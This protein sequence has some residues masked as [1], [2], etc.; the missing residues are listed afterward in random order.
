MFKYITL[1]QICVACLVG[2]SLAITVM[3]IINWFIKNN[4]IY[5]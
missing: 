3:L 2:T 5:S 4:P 1:K